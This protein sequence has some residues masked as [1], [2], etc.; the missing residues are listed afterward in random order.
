MTTALAR[1]QCV[2]QLVQ[3]SSSPGIHVCSVKITSFNVHLKKRETCPKFGF[4]KSTYS[5]SHSL[6]SAQRPR[7]N[8]QENSCIQ[9]ML[10]HALCA[11]CLH[12][13]QQKVSFLKYIESPNSAYRK[14]KKWGA[15][16]FTRPPQIL[17]PSNIHKNKGMHYC[18]FIQT[19]HHI[20]PCRTA[21]A[22]SNF[23]HV[24]HEQGIPRYTSTL[25]ELRIGRSFDYRNIPSHFWKNII[26]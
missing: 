5:P 21:R 8:R 1:L 26:P 3:L 7:W 2:P 10:W 11:A 23:R 15:S 17:E 6:L 25:L 20:Y 9:D 22:T 13:C 19:T 16:I 4:T 18:F 24:T 14:R 12:S